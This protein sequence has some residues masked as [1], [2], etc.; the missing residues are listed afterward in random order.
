MIIIKKVHYFKG[1]NQKIVLIKIE[2]N[3]I[4]REDSGKP[5]GLTELKWS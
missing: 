4:L 2:F 3:R 1:F 5:L